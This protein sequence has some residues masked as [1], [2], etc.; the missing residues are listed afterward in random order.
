MGRRLLVLLSQNPLDPAGGAA[1]TIDSICRLLTPSGYEIEMLGTDASDFI[2]E[3]SRI[4]AAEQLRAVGLEPEELTEDTTPITRARRDGITYTLLETGG[5]RVGF[6]HPFHVPRF[7]HLFIKLM[8]RFKPDIVLT[9]GATT[10]ERRRQQAARRMGAA[11]VL[12]VQQHS[13][14]N[15][16][17]FE[18]A[19]AVLS[20]SQFLRQCYLDR[21]GVDSVA[22]ESPLLLAD[23]V[24]QDRD[25]IFVT[26]VNPSVEKGVYFFARIA[27][28]LGTRRPDI[29]MLVIESRGT[30]GT[31]LAAGRAGGFDLKR[32]E[33]LMTAP[34]VAMPR[35]IYKPSRIVLVPSVWEEPWGRV[36]AEALLNGIPPIVS[37]RGGL[38]EACGQGG[39]MLPIPAD[40][41]TAT[42]IPP[43]AEQTKPWVDLIQLLC[44]DSDAYAKASAAALKASE[45][46]HPD[47]LVARY[48]DFFDSVRMDLR[49][50]L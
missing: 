48:R 31:L 23:V 13:Y 49:K 14:Y 42:H 12:S 46:F 29:P 40:F 6:P 1:R 34:G 16:R 44:D 35:D 2:N 50:P 27:E 28:E 38:A 47:R 9:F 41:T 39:F 37:N 30:A 7:D 11:V 4:S 33:S 3:A 36:A 8:R 32:H 25:P 10:L 43:S 15:V 19:D 18:H 17:A 20:C 5:W 45:A 24:A 22:I 26:F 21:V